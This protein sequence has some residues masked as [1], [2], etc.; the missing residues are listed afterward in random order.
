M[1]IRDIFYL[2]TIGDE[3]SITKAANKLFVAQPALSQCLQKV[4]KELGAEIFVRT[5]SGVR[6]TAEG[7]RFLVFAAHTLSEYRGMQK[8]I[9][10]IKSEGRG[11]VTVGL[12]GTQATYVLPYFLPQ[13]HKKYPNI[14]VIL[15]E[16]TSGMIEE[17]LSTGKVDIGIVH[18]PILNPNLD[19]FELSRDEMVVI[20]RSCSRFQPYIYY[21]EDDNRPYLKT[22][23]FEHEPLVLTP[24]NQRS[25]MVCEQI[26]QKAGIT[27]EVKQ[28]SKNLIALDALAQVDYATT[29]IPSKQVSDALR[30][31]GW[32]YFDPQYSVPYTFCVSTLKNA[33]ISV[34]AR[35][36]LDLLQELQG[37]F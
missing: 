21:L 31:R 14:E 28:V 5:S 17:K 4:E 30:R 27:P 29:I 18:E 36:L 26:F 15:K 3:K 32:Y 10:D 6:P 37:T 7:Q 9:K 16:D 19:Y 12:T 22:A 35:K 33:Y 13:F 25:R 2:M 20:P 23:F 1:T 34:A 8:E 24:S 11:T